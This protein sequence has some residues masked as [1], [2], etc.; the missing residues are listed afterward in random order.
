MEEVGVHACTDVTGFG[1][2]GHLHEMTGGAGLDAELDASAVPVLDPARDLAAADVIPGGTL[3]NLS[4]AEQFVDWSAGVSRVQKVLLADAQ[5][6]GGLL[7]AVAPE[8]ADALLAALSA[9]DVA[10]ARVIGRFRESGAGRIR[11]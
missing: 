10:D 3:D 4:Y 6:S 11:V 8:K 7:I 5:T 1:L 9:R 2:L